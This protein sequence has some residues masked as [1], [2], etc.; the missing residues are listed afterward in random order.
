MWH[1]LFSLQSLPYTHSVSLWKKFTST[2][3][4]MQCWATRHIFFFLFLSPYYYLE[5]TLITRATK[6]RL[7]VCPV[8]VVSTKWF[9][10]MAKFP[11]PTSISFGVLSKYNSS[12]F[13]WSESFFEFNVQ[14][15]WKGSL[16]TEDYKKIF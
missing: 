2:C 16:F 10:D 15:W 12:V 14:R 4:R 6:S 13:V 1:R 7:T 11:L 5:E 8:G 9:K 3:S